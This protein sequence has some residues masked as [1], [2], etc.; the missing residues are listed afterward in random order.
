MAI[1]S[2]ALPKTYWETFKIENSDL[3]F[4][5]NHL[6]ELETPQTPQELVR[7]LIDERIRAEKTRMEKQQTAGGE[8]YYPKDHHKT[9]QS[10]TFPALDWASGKI[11][12]VREGNNP[13]YPAFEV[14]TVEMQDGKQHLFAAGLDDHNLNQP[15]SIQTDDPGLNADLVYKAHGK[16]LI[17][18]LTAVLEENEDLVP[19]AGRWFPRSLLVDVNIGHLNLAE[20]VL[21]MAE[22]GPLTTKNILDQVEL[23][24]DVNSKLTEFSFNLAL[25]EDGRFDE[26]GPAGE[27]LWFLRRLEPEE[28]QNPPIYLR[29]NPVEFDVEPVR[30]L[31]TQL[32]KQVFDEFALTE[33]NGEDQDEISINLLFPHLRA[34]TLPLS[35]QISSFFPSA[36]ESPRVQFTFVDG[37]TGQRLSGWVVRSQKYIFG[38]RDWYASQDL[39]PGST[40]RI[41]RSNKP[42]EVIIKAEKK[43]PSREW[44]RTALVGADGGLVFAMLKQQVSTVYDER[45]AIA[46][47]EAEALDKL[48]TLT[49]KMR[50]TLEQTTRTMM[51]ELSKLNPQGH[52]HA[53]EL[54]A[55]V[56]LVRRCPPG[57]ILSIL[58]DRPWSNY[59]GDLYFRPA[60]LTM[61]DAP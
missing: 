57:P 15:I 33:I 20:A 35:R 54:Y 8:I 14:L 50:G 48:W 5:Y 26:V 56:N 16:R 59:L 22:G 4:L 12:T 9:G 2:L 11:V 17:S 46:I 30:D 32:E 60:S 34:G 52:V 43:R 25:Q 53:Q 3:E 23:S 36:Y 55:A 44:I 18:E 49:G 61:E 51:T 47:P 41:L 10:L 24:T 31:L 42:G 45:M 21:E 38:L 28:V 6:L 29:Y 7:A 58:A 39:I 40:M 19:I 37:N 13:E 27:V 1:A